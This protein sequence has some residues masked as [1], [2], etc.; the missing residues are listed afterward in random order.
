MRALRSSSCRLPQSHQSCRILYASAE[1]ASPQEILFH[2]TPLAVSPRSGLPQGSLTSIFKN[3]NLLKSVFNRTVETFV[4]LFS[5]SQAFKIYSSPCMQGSFVCF[6]KS[7]LCNFCLL[8][9]P[10]QNTS[11]HFGFSSATQCTLDSIYKKNCTLTNFRMGISMNLS[12]GRR[13]VLRPQKA[14]NHKELW[15]YVCVRIYIYISI[16]GCIINQNK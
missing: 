16:K 5:E 1:A 10:D 6:S 3:E 4:L 9:F 12:R 8:F 11:L 14:M 15:I 7:K 2:E 13:S